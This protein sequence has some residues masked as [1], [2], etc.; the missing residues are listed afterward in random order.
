[1]CDLMQWLNRSIIYG[2]GSSISCMIYFHSVI[3]PSFVC[4]KYPFDLWNRC[5]LQTERNKKQ[6]LRHDVMHNILSFTWTFEVSQKN[7]IGPIN[8]FFPTSDISVALLEGFIHCTGPLL[9]ILL[10]QCRFLASMKTPM[11]DVEMDGAHFD[12]SFAEELGP[13]LSS[14][15]LISETRDS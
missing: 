7:E 3:H 4:S 13:P 9:A 15:S 14:H 11:I 6:I 5:L 10:S 1:M 2:E 12:N 8:L